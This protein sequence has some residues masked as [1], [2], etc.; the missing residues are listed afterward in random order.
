MLDLLPHVNA[1]LNLGVVIAI[2][3]GALAIRRGDR[4]A[5]P[6]HMLTA[7][8]IGLLF[9]AGYAT[10]TVLAGHERF[11]GDDW[12]RTLFLVILVTHTTL[13]VAVAPVIPALAWLGWTER[14]EWHRRIARWVLPIWS[15]VAVTG[16]VIYL[17]NRLVRPA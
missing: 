7:I 13:A 1:A 12:V 5:H 3:L 6:R 16:V 17:F 15:Y 11:P 8:G 10:Q 9:V 2:T 14:L 4:V